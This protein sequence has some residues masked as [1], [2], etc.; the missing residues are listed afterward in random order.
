MLSA[1]K[2]IRNI[3]VA[4][5]ELYKSIRAKYKNN[6]KLGIAVN[7]KHHSAYNPKN[8]FDKILAKA[9]EYFRDSRYLELI[10]GYSD[11]I[12][13]NYYFHDRLHFSLGGQFFGLADLKNPNKEIS[14]IGWDI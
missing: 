12:G 14:D 9:D 8:I 1:D 2:V 3:C 11:F 10:T 6:I 5:N 4:H 13:F 7:L